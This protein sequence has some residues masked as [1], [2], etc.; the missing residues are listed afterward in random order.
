M[1][2]HCLSKVVSLPFGIRD[3]IPE[4][5][6]GI[7]SEEKMSDILSISAYVKH[8][9]ASRK[10]NVSNHLLLGKKRGLN[11]K[12]HSVIPPKRMEP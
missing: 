2:R 6:G 3:V 12:L 4:H 11:H 9:N 7:C 10:N 5:I 8:P 1:G